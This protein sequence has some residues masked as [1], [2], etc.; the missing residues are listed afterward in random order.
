[1]I[2]YPNKLDIIFEKLQKNGIKPVIVGGYI[3]DYF[4]SLENKNGLFQA[5]DIDIE[6]YNTKSYEKILNILKEFGNPNIIGKSF[7]VVKLNIEDLEVDFSLPRLENKVSKGHKGF[8]VDTKSD[9][10]FKQASSRRDFTINA[11]GYDVVDKKILDPH[12]GLDDLKNKKLKFVTQDSFIEDPLRVLRAMQFLARFDLNADKELIDVCSKMCKEKLLNE[13]PSERVF[14]EF[15][16]LFTKSKRPSI[17]L[18]FL[19]EVDSFSYFYELDFK[20]NR[21]ESVLEVIDNVDKQKLDEMTNIT[22]ML[23]LLTYEMNHDYKLSFLNKLTR[24]KKILR[25]INQLH[26][27]DDFLKKRSFSVKFDIAKDI[28]LDMLKV[29]LDA[30][31]MQ[32]N[33]ILLRPLVHGKDLIDAGIK[34][35]KEF[36]DILQMIYEVQLSKMTI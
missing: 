23:A 33:L 6:L 35:S 8:E 3:R 36:G 16:K 26:H 1:M 20:N 13:L 31:K 30:Q 5:K 10:S 28:D 34:R 32:C 24:Q 18:K 2:Q 7:G 19:K 15:K 21:Y 14:E 27:I 22:V 25:D 12:S 29:Y 17:G 9:L 11:I 4:L